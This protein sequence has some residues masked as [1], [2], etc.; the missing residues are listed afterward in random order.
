MTTTSRSPVNA[1]LT[2]SAQRVAGFDEVPKNK[3]CELDELAERVAQLRSKGKKV[4]HAHGVFDLLHPGHIRHLR[5][6]RSFGDVLVVTLTEDR[7]VNKG[8]HR[9][10]FPDALRAEA[11]AALEVVDFV[12]INRSPTAVAAID[13]LKPDVYAK[14]PDYRV[15]GDD[16][17]GGITAEQEA[18]M[19]HGGILG[20]TDGITFSSSAL[21]NAYLPAYPLEVQEYLRDLR[22]RYSAKDII[23]HLT[24][25]ADMHVLVVGEAIL[26]E[27]VYCDQMGKSAKEP[28]LAMR[29]KSSE[30]FAGGALAVANHLAEFCKSV[31]VVT[32]LGAVDAQE[33]FVRRNL[34]PKVRL[35]AIHKSN[36]P[37]IVKR[38]YVEETLAMKLFEVYSINDDDLN[39]SE[40]A[41]L[42][43]LL[44]LRVAGADAVIA[45]DFGHGLLT[46]TSKALLAQQ[47][48]FLAVNTQINA[49][50]IRF[51]AISSYDRADYVCINEG[52]LRLDARDRYRPVENLVVGLR[53]K[54]DCNNV[55]VTQG[56]CG[57]TY[58]EGDTVRSSP[59][60][61]THVVDRTGSGDA[62]LALTSVCVASGMPAEI[63]AF[64]ANVIGA[65]KVQIMG[66]RNSIGRVAT[67]KFIDAL[68][69]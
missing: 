42:C 30:T 55:L 29:Y 48:K 47:A 40:E 20:I 62:V 61:A 36:S 58:I 18:V 31:E 64:V 45:A 14:G 54:L 16:I 59:A 13:A 44:E 5:E 6:A 7:Y 65:Q 66:N 8:P 12:A 27:Y 19:A 38:R 28:V 25:L 17:S 46:P 49:A 10:A 24:L 3:I 2:H 67:F 51:H 22:S 37:T 32:Y 15:P 4:V 9:P 43:S 33:T 39:A 1:A 21:I 50:N 68:L 56:R 60:L 23:A 52:E 57:V 63:V 11:M 26:D 41:D 53:S 69:K 35:N 34:K